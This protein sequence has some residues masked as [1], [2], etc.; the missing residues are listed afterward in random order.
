[1]VSKKQQVGF[2][3]G[4]F[5]PIHIGHLQL[6]LEAKERF[7]FDE[8][9]MCPTYVSPFKMEERAC[10]SPE[11]RLK[12]VSLAIEG[13]EGFA[14]CDYEIAEKK[15][16]YTI[17]TIRFLKKTYSEKEYYLILGEDHFRSFFKWKEAEELMRLAPLRIGSRE[18]FAESGPFSIPRESFFKIH[19]LEISSTYLRGVI[20]SKRYCKHL[21]P[22]KVVDYIHRHRL[23]SGS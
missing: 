15:V 10:A 19:N 8:I 4:T 23:Y 14:V 18:G 17:D 6:A 11:D 21:I 2:L 20:A 22:P 1:M 7:S 12:M 9:L 13:I 5:D 3:G 16:S